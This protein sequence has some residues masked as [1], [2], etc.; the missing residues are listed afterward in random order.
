MVDYDKQMNSALNKVLPTYNELAL[1]KDTKTPCISFME[2]SN[3][4]TTTGETLGY[5][6]IVYQIKV[7]SNSIKELKENALRIDLVLRPLGFKRTGS[8]MLEDKQTTMKQ[9]ILTYE[10]TALEEF[11]GGQL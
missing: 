10:A 7:W 1:S 9:F 8:N 6:R 11:I 2:L 5:S 4:D 3:T